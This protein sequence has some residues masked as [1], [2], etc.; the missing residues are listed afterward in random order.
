M[1]LVRS[2]W[3]VEAALFHDAATPGPGAPPTDYRP[4]WLRCL[5]ARHQELA[6]LLG[7]EKR[8]ANQMRQAGFAL[9]ELHKAPSASPP[10]AAENTRFY[11]TNHRRH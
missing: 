1:C 7:Y 5:N 3:H 4:H 6:L 10:S 9:V 8:F 2:I 11:Q